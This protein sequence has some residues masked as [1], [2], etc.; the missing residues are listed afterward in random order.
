MKIAEATRR[1]KWVDIGGENI[2][3][4]KQNTDGLEQDSNNSIC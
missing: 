1:D 2:D 4:T 3:S